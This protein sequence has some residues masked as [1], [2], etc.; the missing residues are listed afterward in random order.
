MVG[1]SRRGGCFKRV[2]LWVEGIVTRPDNDSSL[3]IQRETASTREMVLHGTFGP[4][5]CN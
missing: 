3:E 5:A 4:L 2:T 1:Y